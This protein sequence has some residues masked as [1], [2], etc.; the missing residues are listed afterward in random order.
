MSFIAQARSR[1][2]KGVNED[3][4]GDIDCIVVNTA[5]VPSSDKGEL[6]NLY[7]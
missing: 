5:D 3:S 4:V 2:M 7:L 1:S 6:C